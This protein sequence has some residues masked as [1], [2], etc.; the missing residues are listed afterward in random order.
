MTRP[1]ASQA[2]GLQALYL[3][4]IPGVTARLV[5]AVLPT[6]STQRPSDVLHE[7]NEVEVVGGGFEELQDEVKIEAPG[8]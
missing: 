4:S 8:I 1:N 5:R 7:Q 2:S 6:A 3:G